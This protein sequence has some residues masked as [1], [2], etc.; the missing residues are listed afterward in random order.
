M[1]LECRLFNY[2]LKSY[3]I[4]RTEWQIERREEQ[5]NYNL[6]CR[7]EES[8]RDREFWAIII[9]LKIKASY[10]LFSLRNEKVDEPVKGKFRNQKEPQDKQKNVALQGIT[11][12]D[13]EL[14]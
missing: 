1:L 4:S 11:G 12:N 6:L 7:K 8:K 13:C 9:E 3:E 14:L 2:N 5:I 10:S